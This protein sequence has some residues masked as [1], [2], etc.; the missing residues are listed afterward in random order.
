M[1]Q[2]FKF[3]GPKNRSAKRRSRSLHLSAVRL[4]R[5]RCTPNEFSFATLDLVDAGERIC[6]TRV[7]VA[8]LRR[9]DSRRISLLQLRRLHVDLV[10]QTTNRHESRKG[11]H[12]WI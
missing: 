8:R 11:R 1:L 7:C 12:E 6:W 3:W 5:R 9:S 2:A 4:S 10:T